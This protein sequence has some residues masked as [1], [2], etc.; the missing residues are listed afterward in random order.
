LSDPLERMWQFVEPADRKTAQKVIYLSAAGWGTADISTELDIGWGEIR[1]L[2]S[3]TGSAIVATLMLDG[4]TGEEINRTLGIPSTET[5]L[6]I[7]G[8]PLD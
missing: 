5:K 3:I 7:D 2:K 8:S 1:R 4:Y 6:V